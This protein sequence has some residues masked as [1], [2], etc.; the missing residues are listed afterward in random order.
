MLAGVPDSLGAV[1]KVTS[2]AP[3]AGIVA[4]IETILDP[5]ILLLRVQLPLRPDEPTRYRVEGQVFLESGER[6]FGP[7]E[8]SS[9]VIVVG[10]GTD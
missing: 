4:A 10:V 7:L 9:E 1:V 8:D 5:G 3:P 6:P 2:L